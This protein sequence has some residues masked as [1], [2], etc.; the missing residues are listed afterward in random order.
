MPC[1]NPRSLLVNGLV[2]RV[3]CQKCSECRKGK[4]RDIV[5]R[6]LAEKRYAVGSHFITLTYGVDRRIDGAVNV[7]GAD[8]L[9]YSH[10][11][12]FLKRL[13]DGG[14]P[15]RYLVAGEYGAAK[16]RAHFHALLFWTK[17]VPDIP[18]H[19][20]G[21][22]GIK[23]AW[24]DPWWQPI[25]GGHT[26]WEEVTG[27]SARYVAGYTL[28][29]TFQGAQSVV[30]RST[31]PLLGAKYFDHWAKLHV[32]Q[33]LAIKDRYYTVPDSTDPKTGKLWRY[34]MNDATLRYVVESFR[35]QWEAR[36]PGRHMPPSDFLERQFD[37]VAVPQAD[38]DKMLRRRKYQ[39]R[40]Y[41][42]PPN[43]EQMYFDEK[44][45]A[46]WFELGRTKDNRLSSPLRYW[47]SFDHKGERCWSF[48]FVSVAEGARR[49]RAYILSRSADAYAEASQAREGWR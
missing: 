37:K 16:G 44:R 30:R 1:L 19:K 6:V 46:F 34:Y 4:V 7:K 27:K 42:L 8:V 38:P 22:D 24:D 11:R 3:V 43:G 23:R 29:P 26:Q 25:G 28:K 39:P 45:N 21:R 13:R 2:T 33:G 18:L 32:D 36:F 35:W 47:W 17:R 49:W 48:E 20:R 41:I 10:F 9:T 12:T 40:P 5:G 14:Y 31:R 15:M